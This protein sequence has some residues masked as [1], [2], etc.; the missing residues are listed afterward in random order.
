MNNMQLHELPKITTK[1]KRRL[2]LGHGSGRVKTAGRGTKGQNARGKVA[3][4][5]EGG[6]LRLIKR[7]PF[8]RG[9]GRNNVFKQKPL[10][11][12]LAKLSV[13]PKGAEI[14]LKALITKNIVAEKE[15]MNLGVKIL[16][17]GEVANALTVKL[18][19]SKMAKE[20]IEKAGGKV[21]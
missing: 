5:F 17:E 8:L 15:A 20:K 6:A 12:N 2:G 19:V 21:E 4:S 1:G 10:V 3:L 11:V 9:K 16:G 14:D 18:P 13:F 7:L